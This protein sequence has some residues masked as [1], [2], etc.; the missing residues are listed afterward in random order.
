MNFHT[1]NPNL[2]HYPFELWNTPHYIFTRFGPTPHTL[3]QTFLVIC[4]L[5]LLFAKEKM[6][7]GKRMLLFALYILLLLIQPVVGIILLGSYLVTTGIWKKY[8]DLPTILGLTVIAGIVSLW[9]KRV[10]FSQELYSAVQLW[11]QTQQVKTTIP[12]L[13]AAIGPIVPFALVGFLARIK[14]TQPI[15]RFFLFLLVVGYGAFLTPLPERLGISNTRILFPAYIIGFA[16]FGAV[17]VATIA[18]LLSRMTTFKKSVATGICIG[19][20]F[21][22]VTPTII[23]EVQNR[24]P[25]QDPTSDMLTYLPSSM[26]EAFQFLETKTPYD[27]VVLANPISFMDL[28]V[29]ALSGHRTVNGTAFSD[30]ERAKRQEAYDIFLY[31]PTSEEAQLWMQ[32]HHVTYV[33]HTAFDGNVVV[34]QSS[35][36]F[37]TKIFE[38]QTATVFEVTATPHTK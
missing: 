19:I 11:E 9:L 30:N 36:P 29:P 31:K 16:W 27:D 13:L 21:L 32:R 26:Y 1:D 20:F 35:Y 17:G 33:L 38:S 37:L 2:S 7:R 8:R 10:I 15:E 24:I 22:A 28:R 18:T 4:I 25:K 14:K 3:M 23:V 6:T 12:F 5:S 34:F